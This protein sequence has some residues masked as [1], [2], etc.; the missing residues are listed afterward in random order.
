M[1]NGT[2]ALF[3]LGAIGGFINAIMYIPGALGW[4]FADVPWDQ[5]QWFLFCT[6]AFILVSIGFLGLWRK[7][8]NVIPLVSAIFIFLE[9]ITYY[10]LFYLWLVDPLSWPTPASLETIVT[11]ILGIAWLTAGVS[12]WTLREEFSPFSIVAALVFVAF[13]AAYLVVGLLFPLM[14]VPIPN[15][16]IWFFT[17]L[18]IVVCIYF[19]DTART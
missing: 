16:M 4:T 1:N 12:A 5:L 2:K 3:I 18:S 9:A 10:L 19:L 14:L 17:V 11:I 13:A 7:S 15:W 8:G 6:L